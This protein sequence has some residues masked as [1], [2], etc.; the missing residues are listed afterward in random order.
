MMLYFILS[1]LWFTPTDS[2]V[3]NDSI[4]L[5]KSV[6]IIK[7]QDAIINTKMLRYEHRQGFFCDFEDNINK[8]RKIRLNLGVGDN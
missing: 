5:S 8:G 2:I 3:E 1:I 7:K 6:V 4:S